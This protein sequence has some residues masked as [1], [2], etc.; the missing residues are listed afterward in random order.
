MISGCRLPAQS[1][2]PHQLQR[3][4]ERGEGI[5]QVLHAFSGR[6]RELKEIVVIS[7]SEDGIFPCNHV[8]RVIFENLLAI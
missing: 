6:D 4:T 8:L 5:Q 2:S 7:L 1:P 3:S